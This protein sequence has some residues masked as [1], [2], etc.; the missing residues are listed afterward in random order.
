MR[1]FFSKMLLK[2]YGMLLFIEENRK[3]FISSS[4]ISNSK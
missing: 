4:K 3:L 1:F 2:N